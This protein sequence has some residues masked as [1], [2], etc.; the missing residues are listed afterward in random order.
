MQNPDDPV[1]AAERKAQEELQEK[2]NNEEFEKNNPEF[3]TQFKKDMEERKKNN[4]KKAKDA[5]AL[6]ARGNK[7]FQDGHLDQAERRYHEALKKTPFN[8]PILTNLAAVHTKLK[9]WD[10]AEDFCQRALAIDEHNVKVRAACV[11]G[12]ACTHVY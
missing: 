6:K 4:A 7:L 3:V 11:G 8:I 2:A 9:Q 1:T 10:D 5:E 12:G